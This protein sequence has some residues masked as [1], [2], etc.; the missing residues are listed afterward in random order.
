MAAIVSRRLT[1]TSET[2]GNTERIMAIYEGAQGLLDCAHR[3]GFVADWCGTDDRW[4]QRGC[5][6]YLHFVLMVEPKTSNPWVTLLVIV[7]GFGFVFFISETWAWL[8]VALAIGAVG[9]ISKH[10]RQLVDKLW[11]KLAYALSLIFPPIMLTLIFFLILTPIAVLSRLVRRNSPINLKKKQPSIFIER[12]H[13]FS[14]ADLE[15]MG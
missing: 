5:S 2:D 14:K 3:G 9:V 6:I 8:Y 1:F 10:A 15:Q 13:R 4:R 7:L 12:N 11:M